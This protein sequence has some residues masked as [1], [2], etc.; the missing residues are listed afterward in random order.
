[1]DSPTRL[2]YRLCIADPAA[3]HLEIELTLEGPLPEKVRLWMPT[4]VPG[5]YLIREYAGHVIQLHAFG[6]DQPL[7]A[8]KK[9]KLSWEIAPGKSKTLRV[10]YRVFAP[11]RSV[12][13]NDITESHAF[14]NPAGTFLAVEGMEKEA[15]KVRV[16]LPAGWNIHVA[17]DQD[18]PGSFTAAD[19]DSLVDSPI[20]LGPMQTHR[21]QAAGIQHELVID[22]GENL[23]LEQMLK[24]FPAIIEEE[25]S[26]FGGLPPEIKR[27]LFILLPTE[28]GMGG[29]EHSFSCAL[30][31]PHHQFRPE[32]EYHR[33]LTLVAHEF[34]HIWNVKRIRPEL[35]LR[36]EYTKEVY[37]RLL[38]AFEG[39]TNYYDE[40][41][42][43][44]AGVYGTKRY[45][46]FTADNI[47]NEWARP[48]DKVQ[49]ISDSS[50]DTW[51]KLYRFSPDVQ[52]SQS[53]YYQRGM[54]VALLLDLEI[55][56]ASGD[57]KSL[58]DVLRYLWTEIYPAGKG[59]PEG[60]YAEIVKTSTGVEVDA[61]LQRWVEGTE[62]LEYD[63]AF[64]HVGLRLKEKPRKDDEPHP[65]W[66]GAT[67][68]RKDGRHIA[69]QVSIGGSAHAGGIMA[70]DEIVVLDGLKPLDDFDKQLKL[71]HDGETISWAVFRNGRLVQG[72]LT[73][74]PNPNPPLQ[75]VA[76][77]KA[78]AAQK[79][80]FQ[81]WTHASWDLED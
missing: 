69:S 75:L 54:L 34:F 44:R 53:N 67:V 17:L 29:L 66:L 38:W 18:E 76:V 45:L 33:F 64:A 24:D 4:W 52:N 15:L 8:P 16:E 50:F 1:M 3:R 77:E 61:L 27:Y 71:Y 25:A 57:E 59:V 41:F 65:A 49:S 73:F 10:V 22:G 26:L 35:L 81:E 58:D 56:R 74:L 20:E 79:K 42:P 60:G 32:I 19:Y 80:S 40:I 21:F 62:K 9:D 48:G 31:W 5:S 14:I 55:R 30:A 47:R 6:D 46:E 13:T 7:P 72:K 39:V 63:E 78:T 23:P 37:T 36:Y 11:E 28:K 12:R 2:S 51:I 70:G 68:T 43:L